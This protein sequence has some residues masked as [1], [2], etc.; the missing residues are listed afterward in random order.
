MVAQSA[1]TLQKVAPD[2]WR[3][4]IRQQYAKALGGVVFPLGMSLLAFIFAVVLHRK[5]GAWVFKKETWQRDPDGVFAFLLLFI[6][7][8][9]LI[10]F[11]IAFL[12]GLTESIK[13]L[14]NPEFYAIRDLIL[15]L[16]GKGG[17]G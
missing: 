6:T 16:L 5:S 17:T 15:V 11:T 7:W 12:S 8:A 2:V 3:I 14:I 4:M 9:P 1:A 10:V 13:F